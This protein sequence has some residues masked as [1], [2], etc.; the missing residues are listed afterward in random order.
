MERNLIVIDKKVNT[1][2]KIKII[3]LLLLLISIVYILCGCAKVSYTEYSYGDNFYAIEVQ[4]ALETD[5][6]NNNK[7]DKST[8]KYHITSVM[9]Q[10]IYALSQTY[11]TNLQMVRNNGEISYEDMVVLS[12]EEAF[13]VQG[14]WQNDIYNF[15]VTLNKISSGERLFS[16]QELINILLYASLS[17]NEDSDENQ[18][19]T[20]REELFLTV[21][22]QTTQTPFTNESTLNYERFFME[23]LGYQN[24]GYNLSDV[25]YQYNYVT[26]V[27]RLH[28]NGEVVNL[29]GKYIHTWSLTRDSE[30]N[31]QGGDIVFYRNYT[32]AEAFYI[33]GLCLT[34]VFAITLTL[35]FYF[36]KKKVN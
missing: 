17:S 3:S 31:L 33:L 8:M 24:A 13:S 7:I 5:Q 27:R 21:V 12:S 16:T 20:I 26:D 23:D 11:Y 28:S 32:N 4:I 2:K 14:Y 6:L 30:G 25:Q 15:I 36:K 29:G 22:E 18:N 19:I 9:E 1:I 35:I 34:I 10:E